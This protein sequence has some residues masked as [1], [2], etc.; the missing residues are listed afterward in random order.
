MTSCS[1]VAYPD[2][3]KIRLLFLDDV[4]IVD[5]LIGSLESASLNE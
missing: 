2:E 4:R 1:S 5:S 3:L